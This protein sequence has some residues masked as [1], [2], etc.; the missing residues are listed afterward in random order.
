MRNR[1]KF[2]LIMV[3]AIAY[4]MTA[5]AQKEVYFAKYRY[6]QDEYGETLPKSRG[7]AYCPT[8]IEV[9]TIAK[10]LLVKNKKHG[11]TTYTFSDFTIVGH[12]GG[13]LYD[14]K[15]KKIAL[16]GLKWYTKLSFLYIYRED[17]TVVKYE[18]DL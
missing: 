18:N 7:T 2:I 9:D 12:Q 10:T 16:F 14:C 6:V 1:F 8:R 11:S 13:V 15:G 4:T 3:M 5:N 17:D